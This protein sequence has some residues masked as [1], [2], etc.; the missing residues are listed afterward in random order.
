MII[1]LYFLDTLSTLQNMFVVFVGNRESGKAMMEDGQAPP[2]P[3]QPRSEHMYPL[4]TIRIETVLPTPAADQTL[5]F[6]ILTQCPML[7]DL[8][9]SAPITFPESFILGD[10]GFAWKALVSISVFNNFRHF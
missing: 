1:V 2:L 10:R 7:E 4:K 9:L 3:D 8:Q 6:T 5:L